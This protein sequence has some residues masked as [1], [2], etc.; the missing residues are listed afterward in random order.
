LRDEKSILSQPSTLIFQL[1]KGC[2]QPFFSTFA[3]F[4][5]GKMNKADLIVR[6]A[7]DAG[8]TKMQANAALDSFI[9]AVT[10]TLKADGKVKLVG[11]GTFD[12]YKRKA[13]V[14]RNP[15]NGD[16][17][18]IKARRVARFKAGKELADKL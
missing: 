7:E 10:R 4:E 18:K 3:S 15:G 1:K 9:D 14:G 16:V 8:I 17:I 5:T 13:R 2:S 11:F 6:I 12:S